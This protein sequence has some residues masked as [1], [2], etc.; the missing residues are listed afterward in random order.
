MAESAAVDRGAQDH[1]QGLGRNPVGLV[2]RHLLQER[3]TSL[4]PPAG[5]VL[6][7]G[8][9]SGEDALF[10][11][12]RGYRVLGL[13]P[14]PARIEAARE[15]A[16]KSGLSAERLGFEVAA[17]EEIGKPSWGD[18]PFDAAYSGF[19][20]LNGADLVA[21]GEGL[22][23]V[24]GAGAP[25]LLSLL[26]PHPLP[27][28]VEKAVTGKG[29]GG[30][31]TPR[32]G[33]TPLAAVAYPSRREA[34]ELLGSGFEWQDGFGLGVL[35]PAPAQ[36]AWVAEHPQAFGV[37]AALEGLVRRWPL[38]RDLGDHLVLEGRRR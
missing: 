7:L 3:L 14:A 29:E 31:G 36:A 35:L 26:G 2:F 5:R 4:L 38:L 20:A 28:L 19:G 30:R 23:R 24:L 10:L 27:A 25:L 21:V 9:G 37:L 16:R 32:V 11:A 13:D 34:Q 15:K 12:G 17:A 33:G 6:D 8:C 18:G 1:D 22:R